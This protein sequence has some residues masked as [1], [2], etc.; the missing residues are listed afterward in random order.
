M[1]KHAGDVLDQSNVVLLGPGEDDGDVE[2]V[3]YDYVGRH[4]ADELQ[5]LRQ[6]ISVTTCAIKN[7]VAAGCSWKLTL[8]RMAS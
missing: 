4:R 5:G 2:V 6:P 3:P 1:A 8:S 7:F